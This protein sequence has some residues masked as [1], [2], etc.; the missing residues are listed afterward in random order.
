VQNKQIVPHWWIEQ[1]TKSSQQLNPSYGYTFWVN[2]DGVLW[3]SAPRDALPSAVSRE[4]ALY[5]A[6]TGSGCSEV[7]IRTTE[8]GEENLLPGILATITD[9][10]KARR[11]EHDVRLYRLTLHQEN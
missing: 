8:L 5:C 3:P 9:C 6:F 10:S 2:T 4:S 7:G 11:S 1:A